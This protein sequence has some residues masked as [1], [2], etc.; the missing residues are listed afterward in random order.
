MMYHISYLKIVLITGKVDPAA[1][2]TSTNA[3]CPISSIALS[4]A[5]CDIFKGYTLIF[6]MISPSASNIKSW[7]NRKRIHGSL[8]YIPTQAFED[9]R[10]ADA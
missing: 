3:S 8:N 4:T 5:S 2:K 1:G 6:L 9:V 7:Y 10:M